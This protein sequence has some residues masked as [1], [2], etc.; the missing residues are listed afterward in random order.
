M[1]QIKNIHQTYQLPIAYI[2]NNTMKTIYIKLQRWYAKLS[3]RDKEY[4]VTTSG[5]S[6][7]TTE[8]R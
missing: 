2:N 8:T 6:T 5:A 3:N 1:K 7:N 4:N